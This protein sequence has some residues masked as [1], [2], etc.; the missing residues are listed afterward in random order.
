MVSYR[1]MFMSMEGNR[2][3]TDNLT[4]NDVLEDFMVSPEDMTMEMHM[5]G[6]MYAP[7]NNLTLMAM[8]P[9]VSKEMD[10]ITRGGTT[11]TTNS[12]GLGDIKLTGLYQL[13]NKNR[14]SIHLNLGFSVPTGSIDE[15]YDT[16]AGDDVILPYP[17]QIGSGTLDL[18]PGITYLG[19]TDHW[20]WGAQANTVLRLGENDR[21][22]T[23]GNRYQLTGWAARKL[24]DQFSVSLRLDGETWEDYDGED[25]ALNPNVIPTADPGLRGGTRL[26]LGIGTNLYF[27]NSFLPGGR[28]AAE[29]ELPLYQSL[30][31]PQLETDW[32]FTVGIQSAF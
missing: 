26:D 8:V 29:F 16:P 10:H 6:G 23:V 21:G 28:L 7:T 9:F 22:Y 13:F 27:P 1:Y 32:Q 15:R 17:M 14:Q 31:G 20:S 24:S 3:G 30:D 19:Q 11:F 5:L 18:R 12:Q 2:D 4:T 25:S